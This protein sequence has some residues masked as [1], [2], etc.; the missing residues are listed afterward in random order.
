MTDATS[1]VLTASAALRVLKDT[2][3]I[4]HLT[5]VHLLLRVT[6]EDLAPW[7]MICIAIWGIARLFRRGNGIPNNTAARHR[8]DTHY[9]DDPYYDAD[10]Y[11]EE[12]W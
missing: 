2:A 7:I 1:V 9:S 12:D 4:A 6:L 5:P 11:D 3:A 8:R 10:I